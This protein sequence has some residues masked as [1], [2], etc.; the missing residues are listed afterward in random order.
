MEFIMQQ[1]ILAFIDCDLASG[2]D[3]LAR[4]ALLANVGRF[5]SNGVA[6]LFVNWLRER[7]D[8]RFVCMVRDLSEFNDFM[9]DV[10]RGVTGVRE[11]RTTLSFGGRADIDALLELEME[12]NPSS[13]TVA[14]S[15]WIDIQPGMDRRCFQ[16]LLD[17]PPHP[18]VRRVWLLNCY[19]RDDS[20]LNMMLLGKNIA[21]LTGYVM[22]WVRTTPGVIDTEMSTVLDWRW[23]AGPEDIVELCELFFTRNAVKRAHPAPA[24]PS[25]GGET[26][27]ESGSGPVEVNQ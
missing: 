1:P 12:V 24:Q 5:R 6:P 22:S 26:P 27:V 8:L 2:K 10:V 25:A 13:H 17:L 20:D 21:A 3:E 9:L 4:E 7:A 19:H 15:L 23:L 14:A 16:A 11:T 18:D